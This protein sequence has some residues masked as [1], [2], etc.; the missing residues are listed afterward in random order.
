MQQSDATGPRI[1]HTLRERIITGEIAMGDKLGERGVA[2]QLG[3]SR[4]PVREA[5]QQLEAEGFVSSS[6]R[7]AAIVHTFTLHDARELFDMRL[8]LEPFAAALAAERARAGA[9][10]TRLLAALEVAHVEHDGDGPPSTR[11]SDLHEEIFALAGHQLL[12]RMSG[13]LTGRT[14]WL[15][16]LTP[17]RDT[18]RRWDEHDEIVEAILGGHVELAR[19]LAAA[20]VERGR[21]ESMPRLAERLPADVPARRRRAAPATASTT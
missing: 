8:Q 7:R 20:H 21:V 3:V 19:T 15:F 5:L 2:E 14:R 13:L 12:M 10:T 18:P 11:N 1:A 9:D 17:E 6:H 16:R 4:V